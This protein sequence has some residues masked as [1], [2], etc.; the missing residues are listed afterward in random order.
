LGVGKSIF[1]KI[2]KRSSSVNPEKFQYRKFFGKN[3]YGTGKQSRN[4]PK[5][6]PKANLGLD[7]S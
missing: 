3:M 7:N 4:L 6:I 5:N 2:V 1:A